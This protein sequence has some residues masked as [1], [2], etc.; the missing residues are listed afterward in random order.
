MDAPGDYLM[1]CNSR[2]HLAKWI[3]VLRGFI[4]HTR[5]VNSGFRALQSVHCTWLL[6]TGRFTSKKLQSHS[7]ASCS[8]T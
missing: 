8:I 5:Q 3:H 6:K 4:V 1:F 7:R 2:L